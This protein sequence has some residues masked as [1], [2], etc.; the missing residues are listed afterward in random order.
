MGRSAPALPETPHLPGLFPHLE[1]RRGSGSRSSRLLCPGP[2]RGRPRERVLAVVVAARGTA[3][4]RGGGR[5]H[6]RR[7]RLVAACLPPGAAVL[8]REV[9][10]YS[11][12]ASDLMR[13]PPPTPSRSPP[14]LWPL[15]A[16]VM[17]KWMPHAESYVYFAN[18]II[19][20]T[21]H[22]TDHRCYRG[23]IMV[24]VSQKRYFWT[25][26]KKEARNIGPTVFCSTRQ[27]K[28]FNMCIKSAFK[29]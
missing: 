13:C 24:D 7:R 6:G 1:V 12:S 11:A 28:H 23:G 5:L 16:Q 14:P 21:E 3:R 8:S 9:R 10:R 26:T 15:R 20:L 29:H 27:L 19:H 4:P 25:Q 2:P 18:T 22:L 17:F